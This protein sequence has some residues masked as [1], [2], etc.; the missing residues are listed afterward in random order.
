MLVLYSFI[1]NDGFID[2]QKLG[3]YH[4][5]EVILSLQHVATKKL[6]KHHLV[7]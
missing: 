2:N 3:H 5:L 1:C 4:L 7:L 6:L